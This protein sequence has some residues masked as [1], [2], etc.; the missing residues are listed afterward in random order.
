MSLSVGSPIVTLQLCNF[1]SNE[2]IND[3]DSSVQMSGNDKHNFTRENGF[4]VRA[5]HGKHM[6]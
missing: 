6:R 2:W 3:S 1:L 4:L 5:L